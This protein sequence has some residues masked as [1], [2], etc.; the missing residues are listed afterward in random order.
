MRTVKLYL[1]QLVLLVWSL[2]ICAFGATDGVMVAGMTL[3]ILA[4]AVSATALADCY[5]EKNGHGRNRHP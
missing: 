4:V 3:T 2:L 5:R 1:P